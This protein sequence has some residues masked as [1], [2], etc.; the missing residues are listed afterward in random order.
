MPVKWSATPGGPGRA[1]PRLNQHAEEI[2]SELAKGE[3]R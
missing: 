1:P 2:L 3:K